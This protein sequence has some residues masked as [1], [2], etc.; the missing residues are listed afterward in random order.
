MEKCNI[1]IPS[2]PLN[3]FRSMHPISTAL[4]VKI[5]ELQDIIKR[6]ILSSQ[7]YKV[8]DVFGANELNVCINSLE[9]MFTT[10]DTLLSPIV[11]G[12]K[13]DEERV[14][15]VLQDITNDLSSLFRTFGTHCIEDLIMVC[16]GPRLCDEKF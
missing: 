9:T 13:I 12:D 6:T 3:K 5:T 14:I 10:L 7:R 11:E 1:K 8:L 4:G 2:S 15:C 16:F